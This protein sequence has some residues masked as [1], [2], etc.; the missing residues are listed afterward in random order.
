MSPSCETILAVSMIAGR[1]LLPLTAMDSLTLLLPTSMA[2]SRCLAYACRLCHVPTIHEVETGSVG[3]QTIQF[4]LFSRT[5]QLDEGRVNRVMTA[6]I[7]EGHPKTRA[8]GA[9]GP[10]SIRT[11][12]DQCHLMIG[13]QIRS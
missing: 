13:L 5:R 8:Q 11:Q 7:A 3:Y 2:A 1:L 9:G 12:G 4:G 6:P 10:M